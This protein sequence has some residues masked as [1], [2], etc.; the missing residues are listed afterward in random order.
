MNRSVIRMAPL[1]ALFAFSV[2]GCSGGG[3]T[4]AGDP[5]GG[6][7]ARSAS[8][9]VIETTNRYLSEVTLHAVSAGRR[10]RLG[11]LGGMND[12]SFTVSWPTQASLQIEI[13]TLD[14]SRYLTR[15]IA[16]S[17]GD[18]VQLM[19]ESQLRYSRLYR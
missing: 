5:F 16:V 7:G 4:T 1:V 2:A 6:P 12:R 15:S 8:Q 9:I 17:P 19:V 11:S 10:V 3:T 13:Q 18:A 14:G